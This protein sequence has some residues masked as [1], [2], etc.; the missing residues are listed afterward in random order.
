MLIFWL[1]ITY[2]VINPVSCVVIRDP[3]VNISISPAKKTR[4]PISMQSF[5]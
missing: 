1:F 4:S 2:P 5:M 3:I